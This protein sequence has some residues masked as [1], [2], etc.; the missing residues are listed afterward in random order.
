M[1]DTKL[2]GDISEMMVLTELLQ[3]GYQVL[4]PVGDRLPYDLAIDLNGRFIRFQVRTA[5][6][7]APTDKYVGNVRNAK[8]N[9][10]TYSFVKSNTSDVE[11]FIFV[12]QP[13]RIFYVIPS[14]VVATYASAIRFMPHRSLIRPATNP[15]HDVETFRDR[16]DF[17]ISVAA[18]VA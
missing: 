17:E 10:G 16:F 9:R 14:E 4:Q 15:K 6:H 2:V 5:Y 1:H 13:M 7:D 8:T 18:E 3:R 12:V 11:Y